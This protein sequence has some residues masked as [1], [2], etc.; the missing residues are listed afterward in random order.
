MAKNFSVKDL[1]EAG[2]LGQQLEQDALKIGRSLR[3]IAENEQIESACKA[4]RNE[5]LYGLN[6]R[7]NWLVSGHL[8]N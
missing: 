7:D 6:E 4:A 3:M 2:N 1:D 5:G 8:Q